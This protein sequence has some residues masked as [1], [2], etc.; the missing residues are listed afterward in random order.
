M[1]VSDTDTLIQYAGNNSAVTAY[2]IPFPF[3]ANSWIKCQLL[4]EDG[5]VT[6]LVLDTDYTV[7]GA[8]TAS[9]NLVTA[10]AYD[11]THQLTIYR[12]APL[13]QL[14]DL[15]Y[16]DRL[17][18][19]L[20]EN[21][22]DKLTY[23]AQQLSTLGA[24]GQRTLKFPISEP[25]GND[26]TL[27]VPAL[28]LGK[29]LYFSATTG[30]LDLADA[31]DGV[32]ADGIT[33]NSNGSDQLQVKD[34]GVTNAK[35]ATIA[36]NTIKGRTTAGTGNVEDVSFANLL[37]ALVALGAAQK[38]IEVTANVTATL[39][40]VHHVTASATFTDP[41]PEQGASYIVKVLNGTATVGAVAYA[42]YGTIIE[43]SYHS[44]SWQTNRVYLN[45]AQLDTTYATFA[46]GALAATALQAGSNA[47]TLGSG[48]ATAGQVLTADGTGGADW[49][50]SAASATIVTAQA[51]TSGTAFDF[52][53]I[54]NTVKEITIGFNGV[55]LSGTDD[56]LIQIGATTP[57]TS[58]YASESGDR[59]TDSNST[60]GFVC[61]VSNAAHNLT[62]HATLKKF[63]GFWTMELSAAKL[64]GGNPVQGGG[65][66]T[67]GAVDMVRITRTGTNTFDAGS[68]SIQYKL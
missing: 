45:K 16:N 17:P 28:R 46:Q 21:A 27:P 44:G 34:N 41:T 52:T 3:D 58:G 59:S 10:V 50:D 55:S 20:L 39:G 54:P 25:T 38:P 26:D 9:G 62:G 49:D 1:A 61:F 6:N 7:T 32:T 4:D 65:A 14:L 40:R 48:A 47:D 53:S 66:I 37:T 12:V 13:T 35:L 22:L 29:Y 51:T 67:F 24:P 31:T 64:G 8:G 11:N 43:R 57:T 68:V 5:T 36:T 60:S 56:I 15:V 30:E 33:I 42:T 2:P 18:A 19:Q 23:I 63:D